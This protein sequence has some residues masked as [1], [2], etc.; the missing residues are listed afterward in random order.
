MVEKY[1]VLVVR[2]RRTRRRARG[3]HSRK[4]APAFSVVPCWCPW[5]SAVTRPPV[6][7]AVRGYVDM[8][9]LAWSM[10]AGMPRM[11]TASSVAKFACPCQIAWSKKYDEC[12]LPCWCHPFTPSSRTREF[13][14]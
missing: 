4:E 10:I 2:S 13:L 8:D 12:I 11:C 6:P 9:A 3:L 14:F 5:F 7:T 1:H